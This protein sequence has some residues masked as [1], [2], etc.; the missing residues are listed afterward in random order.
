MQPRVPERG[1]H[2]YPVDDETIDASIYTSNMSSTIA[3]SSPSR[4]GAYDY[5][6]G[7]VA[8][9]DSES[10]VVDL[11][12][13]E[14]CDWPLFHDGKNIS[15]CS[16]Q[17]DMHSTNAAASHLNNMPWLDDI[18][19]RT[20]TDSIGK[21]LDDHFTEKLY[22]KQKPG[23]SPAILRLSPAMGSPQT[24][25]QMVGTP[26]SK[27]E[28]AKQAQQG[29]HWPLG[30]EPSPKVK[31][32]VDVPDGA[33]TVRP[34]TG[35]SGSRRTSLPSP[36]IIAQNTPPAR[37]NLTA[38]S[39]QLNNRKA[40]HVPTCE[41]SPALTD[42]AKQTL[43]YKISQRLDQG[44]TTPY[45]R[46]AVLNKALW[47]VGKKHNA[48]VEDRS[49]DISVNSPRL[50]AIPQFSLTINEALP[51]R[52]VFAN[53]ERNET[54][55]SALAKFREALQR[56]SSSKKSNRRRAVVEGRYQPEGPYPRSQHGC[57]SDYKTITQDKE[58]IQVHER[59]SSPV[60]SAYNDVIH[61][62]RHSTFRL[63]ADP[64]DCNAD[65]D[66][67]KLLKPEMDTFSIPTNGNNNISSSPASSSV[68]Y[69]TKGKGQGVGT[70]GLDVKSDHQRAEALEGLL[71]LCAQ[72]LQQQ[73][74]EEL[75]VVLKPFGGGKVSPRETAIWLTKSLKGMMM[76]D[77]DHEHSSMDVS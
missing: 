63:G 40:N 64:I 8:A 38:G 17:S 13:I 20:G 15:R 70:R 9:T 25:K 36:G 37:K 77:D 69:H 39:P 48:Q 71:E 46:P 23:T 56:E 33:R 28:L 43:H 5:S 4:K 19:N 21:K 57:D 18:G 27:S 53:H 51:S 76:L 72:L 74:Y 34:K 52:K 11:N 42:T 2:D 6:L 1:I 50:D 67:N 55:E 24:P 7:G 75:S 62:I 68:Q 14:P 3:R 16:S 32:P 59:A 22:R 31:S 73:R 54:L 65:M 10:L 61:V 41:T 29:R 45:V 60:R 66:Y 47:T 44:N 12:G 26:H 35:P 30:G 58:A 49:P